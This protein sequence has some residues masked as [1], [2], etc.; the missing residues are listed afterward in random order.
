VPQKYAS[1][2]NK[3]TPEQ[4]LAIVDYYETA[5][6]TDPG[7]KQTTTSIFNPVKGIKVKVIHARA[8]YPTTSTEFFRDFLEA[9]PE[10]KG[11]IGQRTFDAQKPWY[12]SKRFRSDRRTCACI[13][14]MGPKLAVESFARLCE[15]HIFKF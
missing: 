5:G 3:L 11:K 8:Y 13:H 10:F 9:H 7:A 1:P 6:A 12:F 14:H 4:L 15:K 2:A